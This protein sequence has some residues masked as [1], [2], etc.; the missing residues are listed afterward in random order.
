MVMSWDL[1]PSSARKTTPRLSSV[2][3]SMRATF[4]HVV[5]A[6]WDDPVHRT[7]VEGLAHRSL[8]PVRQ[9]G[10][11]PVCRLDDSGL[12]PFANGPRLAGKSGVRQEDDEVRTPVFLDSAP[13]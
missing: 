4:R 13:E 5:G 9:P 8:E 1:S 3:A 6:V 12:L 11:A 10:C 7:S 2:A